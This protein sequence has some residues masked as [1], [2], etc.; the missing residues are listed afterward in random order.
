[1]IKLLI[2]AEETY[3]L[4]WESF[5]FDK[6]YNRT[7][8]LEVSKIYLQILNDYFCPFIAECR[9][10]PQEVINILEIVDGFGAWLIFQDNNHFSNYIEDIGKINVIKGVKL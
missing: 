9:N 4:L 3:I 2:K 7:E 1:M 10:N 6:H 5:N 8:W